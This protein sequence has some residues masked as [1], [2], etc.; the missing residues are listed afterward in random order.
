LPINQLE[1]PSVKYF[2]A[3]G[4]VAA[5]GAFG[6]AIADEPLKF[7]NEATRMNYSIGYQIGGDLKK[8]GVELSPDA[9]RA[10]MQD[11][12]SGA[13]PKMSA[14]DMKSALVELK[15]KIVA[16]QKQRA[17]EQE[18]K[19]AD[20]GAKFM[21]E[22]AKKEGVVTTQS[23]LQYK[24]VQEGTGKSPGPK[25]RVTVNYRGTLIDGQEFDSSYKRDKPT[26]FGLDNV[27]KGWGEGLQLMKEGG[28]AQL[29]IPPALAYGDRGPLA[30]QTLIFDVELISVGP[31]AAES[32]PGAASTHGE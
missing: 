23:G 3:A 20:E 13:E 22:N 18:K 27:I 30:Q 15:Q 26:T 2:V 9:V 1:V 25:D 24:V 16:E 19:R 10:G 32:V 8:Q 21:A 17:S 7:D 6:P 14:A 12:L 29:V 31:Q 11:A 28:K 5:V 4:I